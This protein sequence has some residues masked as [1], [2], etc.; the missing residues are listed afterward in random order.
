MN[1]EEIMS[2][3]KKEYEKLR[4]K[5]MKDRIEANEM[6]ASKQKD[7]CIC[8]GEVIPLIDEYM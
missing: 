5:S 7:I 8:E 1:D 2:V 4:V 6:F 3:I